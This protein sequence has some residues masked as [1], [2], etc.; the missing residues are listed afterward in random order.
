MLTRNL[1]TEL[2]N[3]LNSLSE[4]LIAKYAAKVGAIPPTKNN[5]S[6]IGLLNTCESL[7][8]MTAKTHQLIQV[9]AKVISKN[10]S[11]F[12]V[13]ILFVLK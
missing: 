7:C 8:L 1:K 4:N 5:N 2:L 13:L 12:L 6:C 9:T 11:I 10:N 3:F